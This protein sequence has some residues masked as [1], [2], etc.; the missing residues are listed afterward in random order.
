[1]AQVID[2]SKDSLPKLT[3]EEVDMC[4]KAFAMFDRDASGT[5]DT[6]ELKTALSALGQNP[7]EE[8]LFVMISQVD[9]DGSKCIEFTEFMHV[10]QINKALSEKNSDEQELIDAFCALGGNIDK[11]GRI[12]V[13]KLK[14]ICVDFELTVSVDKMVREADRDYNGWLSYDEFKTLLT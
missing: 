1:M 12:S 4:R 8:E 10:I 3:P 2:I 9:E 5:I 11:T 6:K 13:D 7:S 14:Q